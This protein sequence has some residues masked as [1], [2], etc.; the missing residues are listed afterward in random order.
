MEDTLKNEMQFSCF[1]THIYCNSSTAAYT[2]ITAFKGGVCYSISFHL[3]TIKK[4]E[5]KKKVSWKRAG[6]VSYIHFLATGWISTMEVQLRSG[7][8]LFWFFNTCILT[9]ALASTMN[10]CTA[11]EQTSSA[12]LHRKGHL[13]MAPLA[14]AAAVQRSPE[15]AQLRCPWGTRVQM[16]SL[17]RQL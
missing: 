8:G 9:N 12:L 14:A 11:Q 4:I 17:N 6:V 10:F 13:G 2:T 3:S 16:S 15:H 1:L 5:K 7:C